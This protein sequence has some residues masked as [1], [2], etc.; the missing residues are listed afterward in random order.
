L[1]LNNIELRSPI[2]R[3]KLVDEYLKAD[4]LFLHLND[5]PA[6]EKVLPSKL[7]EYAAFN[8]PIL[9]GLKGYSADFIKAEIS[10]CEVF[11]PCNIDDAMVKFD[12]LNVAIEPRL[13]FINRYKRE[14]IM[15]EMASNIYLVLK[16]N[17]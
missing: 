16:N 13:E 12:S 5:Y 17:A 4:V 15:I 7:F 1:E 11:S 9:A 2:S 10:D 6:F 8:R 14:K 3:K